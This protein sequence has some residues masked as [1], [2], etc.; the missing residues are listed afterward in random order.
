M[1][2]HTHGERYEIISN[3]N[4]KRLLVKILE[5]QGFTDI[6]ICYFKGFRI[7]LKGYLVLNGMIVKAMKKHI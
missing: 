7:P 5:S 1:Y 3:R 2:P 4:I 6:D